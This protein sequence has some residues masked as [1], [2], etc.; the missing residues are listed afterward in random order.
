MA[1]Y[2]PAEKIECCVTCSYYYVYVARLT[3]VG[4]SKMEGEKLKSFNNP[5]KSGINLTMTYIYDIIKNNFLS[6]VETLTSNVLSVKTFTKT[7]S[8]CFSPSSGIYGDNC[9]SL[10]VN[11]RKQFSV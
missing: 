1:T 4:H 6:G 11:R 8:A 2:Y 3:Y 7:Y 10:L 5:I 9:S